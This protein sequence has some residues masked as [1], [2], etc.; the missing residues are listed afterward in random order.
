[1][2]QRKSCKRITNQAVLASHRPNPTKPLDHSRFWCWSFAVDVND[3]A[4][5]VV[6]Y[7]PSIDPLNCHHY[8]CSLPFDDSAFVIAVDLAPSYRP[9]QTQPVYTAYYL[10][11]S[12]QPYFLNYPIARTVAND[13]WNKEIEREKEKKM[14]QMIRKEE[15][16][17]HNDFKL[18]AY[19]NEF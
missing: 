17:I 1:M 11:L 14:R 3:S 2:A 4:A 5:I 7:H 6:A 8:Y 16:S 18:G 9:H 10:M 12:C 13:D 19:S 15:K